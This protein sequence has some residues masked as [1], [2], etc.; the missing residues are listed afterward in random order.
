MSSVMVLDTFNLHEAERRLVVKALQVYGTIKEASQA[1][2]ISRHTL[3][4]RMD[5]HKIPRSPKE[6]AKTPE[7]LE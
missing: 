6:S 1:L 2:G 5:R 4:R 3:I 7:D